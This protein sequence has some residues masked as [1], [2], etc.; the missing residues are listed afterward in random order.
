MVPE[1]RENLLPLE[2]AMKRGP[3]SGSHEAIR[4]RL[5]SCFAGT[6]FEGGLWLVGGSVRDPLLG[7][8]EPPDVDVAVLGSALQ[9]AEVVW[10]KG[11]AKYPP[12]QYP[13]FGTARIKVEG[14]T[15]EF[16]STR[17]ESYR[18]DSRKPDV[19]PAT[20]EEDA[21]RRDFTVN[22]LFRDL[23][24]GELVD[25]TGK[26]LGDL[27]AR[28]LR[29]PTDP[30]VTFSDDPLRM[31]RAI[32]FRWSLGFDPAPGLYE[33]I[34]ANASRLQIISG[35]RIQEELLKMLSIPLASKCFKDL[36]QTGLLGQFWS[37][38]CALSGVEQGDYHHLDVWEHTLAVLDATNPNDSVLRLAAL[39]HD[40]AKPLTRSV[41]P[42]GRVRFFGHETKGAELAW[43]ML[44]RLKFS[45]EV[46]DAVSLLV[47]YHMRLAP[48]RPLSQPAARRLIRDVGDELERLLD[49][50]EADR[51]GH[52]PG[53]EGVDVEEVRAA[54][55]RVA[56]ETPREKI[57]SPLDGER[58]M[59][60]TGLTEGPA[61]GRVKHYLE[62]AVIEGR[63][64]P[65]DV[66]AAEQMIPE[67]LK[68]ARGHGK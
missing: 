67:A 62:E 57:A 15:I 8:P 1:P 44:R 19:R 42:D 16:A 23:F 14:I 60:L 31:L 65:E 20:L 56:L 53:V 2:A 52:K 36:R 66:S 59:E 10:E 32:R 6:A 40:I 49:L 54:V 64:A 25:P 55:E 13:R 45:N 61:V 50:I 28:V 38:L 21:K 22:A 18:E 7:R 4:S 3:E 41:E 58:I 17:A 51:T 33:A 26:G 63:L 29:T 30:A 43:A 35:E 24:S 34:E 11:L 68:W 48:G 27:Q 12:V 47:R 39:F 5:A 37:E 46:V 9:A